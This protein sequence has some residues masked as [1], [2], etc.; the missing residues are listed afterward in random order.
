MARVVVTPSAND[1]LLE[2]ILTH[3]LPASTIERFIRSIEPLRGF[4]ELGAQLHGRWAAFRFILGP[5]RWMII[6]YHH[7]PESDVV[8]IVTIQDGRSLGAPR[9]AV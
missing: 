5:W 3:S 1:D 8:A 7:D 4:P 9:T 2:L 6:V